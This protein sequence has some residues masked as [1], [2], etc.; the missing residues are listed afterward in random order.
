MTVSGLEILGV[1]ELEEAGFVDDNV[2]DFRTVTHDDCRKLFL[3]RP[4]QSVQLTSV[5]LHLS[6]SV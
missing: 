6:L 5:L 2:A 1:D 3:E 4:R